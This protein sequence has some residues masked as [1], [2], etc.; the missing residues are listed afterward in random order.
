MIK[1]FIKQSKTKVIFGTDALNSVGSEVKR[2]G[3]SCLIHHDGGAYLQDLIN[4]VKSKLE[5]E[6]IQVYELSGVKPNPRFS[7][8][9]EG[10]ELVRKHSIDVVLAIGGGSTMDSSKLIAFGVNAD[11]DLWSYQSYTPI[12]HQVL[13]H[14]VISTLP[15]TGSEV[16]AASMVLEDRGEEDV[17]RLFGH[18]E[19]CFDFAI[20]NPELSFTLP[21][22]QMAASSFDI[23]SHA[24]EGYFTSTENSYLLDG[25]MET[26]VKTVLRNALIVKDNPQNY[27]ARANLWLSSIMAMDNYVTLSTQG[28]W[29]VHN[30]EKPLTSLHDKIHGE[31][32]AILTLAWM[33]F[34]HQRKPAQFVKW[35]VNC[36]GAI[37]DFHHPEQTILEGIHRLESW[38]KQM[39]MPTRLSEVGIDESSFV[40]AAEQALRVAGFIGREGF[41]G[42][43]S[44]LTYDEILQVY[45]LAL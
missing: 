44:K 45:R 17:K 11:F 20:I 30:I 21:P 40:T 2:F 6:G 26:V 18:P 23:V 15:G 34:Y 14:G 42:M 13:P 35:A 37:E 39:G 33:R 41:I 7:L 1:N 29:V 27:D 19:I 9:E 22:R 8:V 31:M 38:M 10:I 25:Y 43:N 12:R 5:A 4:T 16:S 28:D 36:M 24:L 32:L 3:S